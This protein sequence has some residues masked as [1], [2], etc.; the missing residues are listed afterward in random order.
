MN[1][2][3]VRRL[4]IAI[5]AA[6]LLCTLASARADEPKLTISLQR[7]M[8]YGGFT[9]DIEGTFRLSVSGPADLTR[10]V[11]FMDDD[12]MA[13]LT[14]SP[15][16]VQFNTSQ[17]AAGLH[18]M[19]AT[20]TTA[21][22]LELA[23]NEI[24]AR[25]LTAEQSRSATAG[26]IIPLLGAILAFTLLSYLISAAVSRRV[27]AS[28]Q[29]TRSYGISGGAVCH[30]CGRPFPLHW[31]APHLATVKLE[32]CPRC[33]RWAFVHAASREELTAAEVAEDA[34]LAGN[35]PAPATENAQEKL[36]K[37]LE[38]SRFREA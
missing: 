31:W 2:S 17:F 29:P 22:G 24:R 23:S 34:A 11:I 15:F 36:R 1:K 27:K 13:D 4:A 10:V 16:Q 21:G 37:E 14:T 9:G 26:L 8:G 38:D 6:C 3:P 28:G 35:S 25:F 19:R 20:G 7:L 30:R 18:T 32:R 33:G 12:S 5:V